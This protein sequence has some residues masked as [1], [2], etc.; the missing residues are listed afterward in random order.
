MYGT[1]FNLDVKDGHKESLLNIMQQNDRV[2]E[3]MV[4]W[5]LMN[6]SDEGKDLIGVAVFKNKESHLANAENPDQHDYFVEM[7]KHL[8]S[9][10]T[11]TDGEYVIG[12]IS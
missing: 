11:W 5:F 7:M 12:E 4:A 2:P 10:P 3:G 8:N 9:E 1:I 6:P